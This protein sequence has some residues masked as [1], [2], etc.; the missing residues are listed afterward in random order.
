MSKNSN[1]S[2]DVGCEE[3]GECGGDGGEDEDLAGELCITV[4]FL[5][6]RHGGNREGRCEEGDEN[7][8]MRGFE[9]TEQ[10]R[11]AEAHEGGEEVARSNAEQDLLF[12]R[13]DGR[14]LC[15]WKNTEN[16]IAKNSFY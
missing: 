5:R 11:E 1:Q 16:S 4:H 7:G 14:E 9:A 10:K 2:Q 8:E 12:Q 6:H 3:H 13:G 15:L